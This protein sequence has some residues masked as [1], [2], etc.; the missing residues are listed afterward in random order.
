MRGSTEMTCPN[1]PTRGHQAGSKR[2]RECPYCGGGS[3]GP[4]G[5]ASGSGPSDPTSA[6]SEKTVTSPP[7][8]A[9]TVGELTRRAEQVLSILQAGTTG[10]V[11]EKAVIG[12]I[13]EAARETGASV[14]A[15]LRGHFLCELLEQAAVAIQA[16]IDAPGQAVNAVVDSLTARW[17]PRAV[18][19]FAV[20]AMVNA[21]LAANP[22]TAALTAL[23]LQ[24][25]AAAVALCPDQEQHK[26]LDATCAA[27]LLKA[28][29]SHSLGA[30]DPN[31]PPHAGNPAP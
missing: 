12:L 28:G 21:A 5:G 2:G 18:L 15:S 6:P 30:E 23:H 3:G 27:P 20:K 4:G 17:L 8:S 11:L 31:D 13:D 7:L 26:S 14:D 25:A 10:D 9:E 22:A 16:L 19:R 24:I 29:L 1:A